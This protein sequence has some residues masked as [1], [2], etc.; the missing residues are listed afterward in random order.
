MLL[1]VQGSKLRFLA[2]A[3]KIS[4][5]TAHAEGLGGHVLTALLVHSTAA[6]YNLEQQIVFC[7]SCCK[8]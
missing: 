5:C 1:L 6:E 2:M 3:S 4:R 7:G 8:V